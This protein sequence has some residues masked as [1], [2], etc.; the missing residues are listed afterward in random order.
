MNPILVLLIIYIGYALLNIFLAHIDA[1]KIKNNEPINHIVNSVVY[2]GLLVPVY[3]AI[4]IKFSNLL[5]YPL[6]ICIG[7]TLLRKF[8]FDTALNILRGLP[9]DYIST[10]TTSETDQQS[11]GIEEKI[12][13][14]AYHIIFLAASI[15]VIFVKL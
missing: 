6:I 4:H 15:G 14:W 3:L 2:C 11:L 1:V 8:V 7:L 13:Y 9:A 12:G 5:C 10:T